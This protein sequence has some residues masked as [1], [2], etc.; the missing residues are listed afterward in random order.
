MDSD[1]TVSKQPEVTREELLGVDEPVS[2]ELV[3]NEPMAKMVDDF[4]KLDAK[5]QD[6][7]FKMLRK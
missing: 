6:V 1:P 2:N 7:F 3:S 4:M 5:G